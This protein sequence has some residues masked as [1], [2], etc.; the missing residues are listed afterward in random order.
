MDDPLAY[1]VGGD[2]DQGERHGRRTTRR[3]SVEL[4]GLHEGDAAVGRGRRRRAARVA[5]VT[6]PS[7]FWHLTK[8]VAGSFHSVDCLNVHY[9][10]L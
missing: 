6:K 9:E 5:H 4:E 7:S 3:L 2:R 1:L 10:A 8:Y